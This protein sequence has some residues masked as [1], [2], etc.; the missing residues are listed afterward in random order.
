VEIECADEFLN[1]LAAE[2]LG[3]KSKHEV[4]RSIVCD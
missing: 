2:W 3:Q 4:H 1:C